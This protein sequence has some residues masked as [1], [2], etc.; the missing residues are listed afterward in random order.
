VVNLPF[1]SIAEIDTSTISKNRIFPY[2]I[3]MR[4]V[5]IFLLAAFQLSRA[6]VIECDNGDRYNGKVLSMDEKLVKLQNDIAGTLTIPRTRIVSISF[7]P[8]KAPQA[9]KAST[10]SPALDPNRIKVDSAAVERVQNE[11]L[12]TATPEATQ[13]F[14]EMIRGL[15]SGQL[16]LGDIR[17]QAASTLKELRDAQKELGDDD[18]A[19]LLDSYGAILEN[20]IKQAPPGARTPTVKP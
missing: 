18:L 13:M 6:D 8:A 3:R 2:G 16:N 5:A 7:R 15:Q 4:T 20:F 19:G 12:S 11:L 17:S 9:G 1:F 10:N 14:Q